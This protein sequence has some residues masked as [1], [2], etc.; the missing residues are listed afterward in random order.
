MEAIHVLE[1]EPFNVLPKCMLTS[2][3]DGDS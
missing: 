1:N 2:R 3:S